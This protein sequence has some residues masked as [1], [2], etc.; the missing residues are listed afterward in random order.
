MAM[1]IGPNSHKIQY[2]TELD[3]TALQE[4]GIWNRLKFS[5][6]N[7][8]CHLN[9]G[10]DAVDVLLLDSEPLPVI[11]QVRN[12]QLLA[13]VTAWLCIQWPGGSPRVRRRTLTASLRE[14]TMRNLLLLD[15]LWNR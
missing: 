7:R 13:V 2:V 14:P 5:K 15:K 8:L 12:H 1:R 10:D 4:Y 11:L 3:K 6:S 9:S